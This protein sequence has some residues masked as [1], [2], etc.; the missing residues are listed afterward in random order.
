MPTPGRNDPCP[1]G[2]G[3]KYKKCCGLLGESPA[4]GAPGAGRGGLPAG[5]QN[6]IPDEFTLKRYESYIESLP[7]DAEAPSLMEFLGPAADS[8][9]KMDLVQLELL[10]KG[11]RRAVVAGGVVLYAAESGP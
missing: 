6:L 2:S 11:A 9:F 3:K 10:P 7:D 1:Y 5:L 4:F 8:A